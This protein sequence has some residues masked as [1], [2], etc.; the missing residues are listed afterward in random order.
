GATAVL[1]P[2]PAR[3]AVGKRPTLRSE[4][5][6]R[7]KL[8]R[9][10][11]QVATEGVCSTGQGKTLACFVLAVIF[12]MAMAEIGAPKAALQ[13]GGKLASRIEPRSDAKPSHR[14]PAGAQAIP[15]RNPK[16]PLPPRVS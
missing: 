13:E 9:I 16:A 14:P 6:P 12:V 1:E 7:S 8:G 10:A 3:G 15:V 2:R 5:H 11:R 4:N